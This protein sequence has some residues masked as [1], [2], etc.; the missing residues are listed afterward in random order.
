LESEQARRVST[1]YDY[2]QL[3]WRR[4]WVIVPAVIIIP[5]V[6]IA[7]SLR[8][9]AV[10]QSSAEVLLNRQNLA[11]ELTGVDDPTLFDADRAA[12]TSAQLARVPEVARR[13]LEAAGLGDRGPYDLLGSS[14][15]SASEETDLLT[16]YVWQRNPAIAERLAT[17]YAR[18]FIKYRLELDTRA[19]K[20][21]R[22]AVQQSIDDLE[23]A[24]ERDSQLYANLVEKDNQLLTMEALLTSRAVL[25]RPADGAGQIQPRPKRNGILGAVLGLAL[26]IGLAF[27]WEALDTRIRSVDTISERLRLPLL[28]RLPTPSRRGRRE[29][30]KLPIMLT[31]PNDRDAE[32]FR[33]LRTNLD[34]AMD[35]ARLDLRGRTVLVTSG[36]AGE[37]KSTTAANLA[38]AL[39][40]TGRRI[41]LVD[42]DLRGASLH[43][44]FDVA[45][46][47]GL[48]DVAL[49][50]VELGDALTQI[51]IAS[52][53]RASDGEAGESGNGRGV[54][55]GVLHLLTS[56]P[57]PPN[58][59]EF[60]S[61]QFLA[62]ILEQLKESSDVVLIDGPPL[63][64]TGDAIEL[65]ALVDGLLLVTR[66]DAI[67]SSMLI[68]L[69][70]LLNS[71]PAAKLGL[72]VTGQSWT[73]RYRF[74]G[75]AAISEDRERVE[76]PVRQD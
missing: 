4:K 57:L 49:G 56:G 22:T 73:H 19:L 21:Q 54:L 63:L 43:T 37:G 28:A 42:V 2:L 18:Q 47:P 53:A 41:T 72:V 23:A 12:R 75:Y 69:E 55:D 7:V 64:S 71:A 66:P 50:H 58:P 11:A 13:T 68:D 24:G 27:L 61:S 1:L 15:V 59:G 29:P 76:A 10:Y 6:A 5:A 33:I 62:S 48:T 67:R 25:V 39:A 40:R 17:E 34:F 38:V 26:G 46:R 9:P 36:V 35:F 52:T 3:L 14:S 20:A 60:I 31:A 70:R 74:E 51:S 30:R 8:E 44:L 32:A 16:F 45:V 65:S